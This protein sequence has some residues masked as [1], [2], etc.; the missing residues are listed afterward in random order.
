MDLSSVLNALTNTENKTS[1]TPEQ[2]DPLTLS[3]DAGRE[4]NQG[5]LDILSRFP[6]TFWGQLQMQK[7]MESEFGKRTTDALDQNFSEQTKLANRMLDG[8]MS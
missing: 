1:S 5:Y 6:S 8:F 4:R 3:R 7:F 2:V